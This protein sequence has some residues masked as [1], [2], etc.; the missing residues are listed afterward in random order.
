MK[1]QDL[2]N[3]LKKTFQLSEQEI[4]EM[5]LDNYTTIQSYETE[6]DL[7]IKA[8]TFLK[9]N[10]KW[11]FMVKASKHKKDQCKFLK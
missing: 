4:I 8:L 2:C 6:E 7:K 9:E 11:R 1:Y 10:K 5:N 3:Y